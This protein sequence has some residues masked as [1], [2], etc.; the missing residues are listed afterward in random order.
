[1]LEDKVVFSPRPIPQNEGKLC[2]LFCPRTR[3]KKQEK[4]QAKV[5]IKAK[6]KKLFFRHKEEKGCCDRGAGA[7]DLVRIEEQRL[8]V[9][10]LCW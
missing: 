9:L 4:K 8:S 3:S 1:L 2:R 7:T 6:R 5:Q 10:S